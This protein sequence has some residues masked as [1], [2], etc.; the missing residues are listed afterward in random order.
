[1][2]KKKSYRCF[3]KEIEALRRQIDEHNYNYYILDNPLIS[4][5]Q[6]DR[7]FRQLQDLEQKHPE[8]ITQDSPTQ[9]VGTAPLS[10][11]HSVTHLS[12]M[13]SLA[14]A[15]DDQEVVAF[16]QRVRQ[17]LAIE[18]AEEAIE[19]VCETK[20][21]GVA[22]SLV[23]ENGRLLSAATR[24]DGFTGEDVTQNIRTIS[25]VPLQLRSKT[26]PKLLEVR[27]EVYL[28]KSEF[29]K[30]NA[31]AKEMGQKIFVN[32][33]NAAA[34]SLRQLD[35][36]I[37]AQRA[38]KIYCFALGAVS[39]GFPLP[40]NHS[41][42]LQQLQQWGFRISSEVKVAKGVANCLAYYQTINT[43]RA[44]LPYQ[45]DGVVYKVNSLAAQQKLGFVSRAPRWAIAHKFP[46]Q[47][48]LTEVIDISFNVG[49][50]GAVTPAAIL[51]PVFVGGAT[52]R[53]ATLHN[54]EEAL[55][56]DI[57]KGDTVIVRRAGDVIPEVVGT[58]LEKRPA[59]TQPITL[60]ANCPVCGAEVVKL[61]GEVVA[62]CTGKLFC[63]AQLRNAIFHFA[64][65]KAMN[66]EGLGEKVIDQLLESGLI[67]DVRGL[68]K[69]KIEEVAALPR[70]GKK[71]AQNLMDSIEKSK[72]T[73]LARFL[74]ALGIREVGEA[75]A[76]NLA[77]HFSNI[78]ALIE[79]DETRLQAVPDIGPVS[80]AHIAAFFQQ[81]ENQQII[82]ELNQLGIHWP[83]SIASDYQPLAG[84]TFV[85]TGT[86]TSMSRDKAKELIENLGA[87]LVNSVSKKTSYLVAGLH[88]GSKYEKAVA[89]A[90]TI[91]NETEFLSLMEAHQ[92]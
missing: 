48:E 63:R 62:R 87:K 79:A 85:I 6:Y 64:S 5:A 55:R 84:F 65:R 82:A 91:L 7:L 44:Q 58:V 51:K 49:R 76:E 72:N 29:D 17:R 57:R 74:Y 38:L 34:G 88:P 47:E 69:L 70:L 46:A 56:K 59:N 40:Q 45:I 12:P 36:R 10:Q 42:I 83:E 32:P 81:Q 37:T 39:E 14:N 52:I 9:R 30:L 19:Y 27:G 28:A 86:L 41:E 66:I 1:M 11:F 61:E 26:I 15:F 21:D 54:L 43:K 89:L 35:S 23:Y 80:A 67:K 13:L 71:S 31:R 75:T 3:E 60:P 53:V 22:I 2:T 77:R 73:T 8:L 18:Q 78:P 92:K 20:L 24:G 50:T 68:Y 4:D 90:I 16:D 25:A 33:R